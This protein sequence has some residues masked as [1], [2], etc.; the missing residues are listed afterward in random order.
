MLRVDDWKLGRKTEVFRSL[1]QETYGFP[2]FQHITLYGPF[3]AMTGEVLVAVYN[4]IESASEKISGISFNLSGY[5]RLKSQRGQAITH[6]VVP[7]D[8]LVR[9]HENIWQSLAGIA[10]SLSLD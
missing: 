8:E 4:A 1:V 3:L 9:F 5:L 6:R 10:P 2:P 7:S